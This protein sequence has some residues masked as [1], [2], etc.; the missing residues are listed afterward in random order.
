VKIEATMLNAEGG[1]KKSEA[2]F[3]QKSAGSAVA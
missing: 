2:Y 3:F 1:L